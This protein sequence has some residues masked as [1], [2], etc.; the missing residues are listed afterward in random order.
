[1]WQ[2][3]MDHLK[4]Q[5]QN[6]AELSTGA[7]IIAYSDNVQHEVKEAAGE[8]KSAEEQAVGQGFWMCT[9]TPLTIGHPQ[10]LW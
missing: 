9:A 5:S 10:Q 1:M 4:K 2:T 8:G 3:V 7:C 6:L